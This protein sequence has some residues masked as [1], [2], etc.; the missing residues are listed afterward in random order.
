[1]ASGSA[2]DPD[3]LRLLEQVEAEYFSRFLSRAD[4][5]TRSRL[6]I[7]T[8]RMGGGVV[9]AMREDRSG[10]WTKALGLGFDAPVD[11]TL[12]ADVIRF[13][14]DSGA[15]EGLLA[16]PA[17]VLPGDWDR[18]RTRHG[19]TADSAWSKLSRPV[20]GATPVETD[21]VIRRLVP[22]DATAWARILREAFGSIDPDPTPLLAA[23]LED[24]VARVLGAWDNDVL[25]GAGV[26]HVFSQVAALST[27]GTLPSHRGRGVQSALLAARAAVAGEAGCRLLTAETGA[28]GHEN[29]S[30]RNLLRAGF[31]HQY[32]RTNWRWSR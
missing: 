4:D 14:K 11:D 20:E 7:R 26:V 6:G 9:T 22:A 25:V 27:G 1:M 13:Q 24:P 29:P 31:S 2:L 16:V 3:D 5:A 8:T 21:F 19:L 15:N 32:D 28:P 30:Y 12:L 17:Q 18:L 10:T 23:T